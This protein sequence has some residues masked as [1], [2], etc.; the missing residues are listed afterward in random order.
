[1]KQ[2]QNGL[3]DAARAEADAYRNDEDRRLDGYALVTAVFAAL[4]AGAA[5]LAFA[6]GRRLPHGIGPWD[7]LL[8][9]VGTHK[10]SRT[11]NKDS[12]TAPL[13][14]RSPGTRATAGRPR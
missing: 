1:M 7:V 5:G 9:A 13:R 3:V 4:V 12:V 6:T 8:L 2:V 11:I 14:A 10:L